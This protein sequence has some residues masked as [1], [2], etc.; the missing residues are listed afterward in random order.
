MNLVQNTSNFGKVRYFTDHQAQK[1]DERKEGAK[2]FWITVGKKLDE[3]SAAARTLAAKSGLN[4]LPETEQPDLDALHR[5]LAVEYL[6]HLTAEILFISQQ[7][8][9]R[10]PRRGNQPDRYRRNNATRRR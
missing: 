9:Q 3:F 7:E 2:E 10:Q 5:T 4:N 8:T 6:Q 1:V